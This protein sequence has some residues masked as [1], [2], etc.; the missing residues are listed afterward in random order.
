MLVPDY[1]LM[2]TATPDDA[3]AEKFTKAAEITELHRVTVARTRWCMRLGSP[4]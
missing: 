4:G 3:D 2:I 1:S